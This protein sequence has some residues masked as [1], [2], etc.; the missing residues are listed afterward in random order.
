MTKEAIVGGEQ[1]RNE[2]Q[3]PE[4]AD[5]FSSFPDDEVVAILQRLAKGIGPSIPFHLTNLL[6]RCDLLFEFSF[7]RHFNQ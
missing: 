4:F 2:M 5:Q 1:V 7:C 3:N 6:K